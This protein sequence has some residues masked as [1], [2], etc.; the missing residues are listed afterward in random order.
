[1]LRTLPV[2][3]VSCNCAILVC[4]E[5]RKAVV[6]D[7][8]GDAEALL[9]IL[10]EERAKPAA[11]LHTHGHIDHFGAT[12]ALHA[13][14]GAP[15]FLHREDLFLFDGGDRQAEM[16]GLEK[17]GK[18]KVERFIEEGKALRFGTILLEVLHTPGHSPGSVSFL[19]PAGFEGPVPCL[20]PGDALFKGSI[21]RTD[22]W[23]GD[24]ELLL[25]SLK[26]RI[27]T[28]PEETMVI[29]G[30]GEFTTVGV[31]KD[32]NPFLGEEY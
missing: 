1:M 20:F 26:E 4:P 13:E 15:V 10:K 16:F 9:G 11:L 7:P 32:T 19:L 30:H 5:T 29:P 18:V 6:I 22:L 17:P 31:E 12:A 2:G 21:G 3:P 24:H 14:T 27:L 25:R 28:L 23:G 8:G